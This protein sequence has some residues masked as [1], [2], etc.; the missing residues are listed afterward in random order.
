[1]SK[2]EV[3]ILNL[4]GMGHSGSTLIGNVLGQ[5]DGFFAV[6]EFVNIWGGLRQGI[7]CGCGVPYRD[8]EVWRAVFQEAFGGFDQVDAASIEN[9]I[10]H[11]LRVH[12]DFRSTVLAIKPPAPP[13]DFVNAMGALYLAIRA[14]TG[15]RVVVDL[16][17]DLSY[18]C[19]VQ[20]YPGISIYPLHLVRDPRATLYSYIRKRSGSLL[21]T[22][23][24]T[25]LWVRRN[26]GAEWLWRRTDSGR[27]YS[28]L[29]YDDFVSGPR[30]VI[31]RVLGYLN[32]SECDL[33]FISGDGGQSKVVL[34]PTH[35]V[36]G[37]RMRFSTGALEIRGDQKWISDMTVRDKLVS[38]ILTWPLLWRYHYPL[39]PRPE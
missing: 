3:K 16:S 21:Y 8:C 39:I 12:G 19:L 6:G 1:M 24:V 25:E 13:Q 27:R 34:N 18:A 4:I 32:E 30:K 38:T 33:P 22:L 11:Y 7:L 31:T 35:T 29:R 20:S 5:L 28:R 37:N 26:M 2:A 9:Q 14:V 36:A 15:S 17:R 23:M 10:N